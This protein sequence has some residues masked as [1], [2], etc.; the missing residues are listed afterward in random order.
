MGLRAKAT[1]PLPY[2]TNALLL[3]TIASTEMFITRCEK[4]E[5]NQYTNIRVTKEPFQIHS[6]A[7]EIP[8]SIR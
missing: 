7:P 3:T 8:S 4:N 6:N 1:D 2:R 5:I